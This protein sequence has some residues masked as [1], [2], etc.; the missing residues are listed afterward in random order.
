MNLSLDSK[1]SACSVLP[2]RRHSY[3]TN[4]QLSAQHVFIAAKRN[5]TSTAAV[6]W[7][8][9]AAQT[10]TV[11]YTL[12]ALNTYL[13]SSS[14]I[15]LLVFDCALT[16][17]NCATQIRGIRQKRPRLPIIVLCP[18]VCCGR[19]TAID[20]LREGATALVP[21]S[22]PESMLGAA[23]T[24][25]LQGQRFVPP[26]LLVDLETS[27]EMADVEPSHCPPK[28]DVR[29]IYSDLSL[30]P[31]ECD[32]AKY[33]AQGHS[34][35]EIA[36]RLSIQEVTVKVYASSIYRKLGVR[37]RTQAAARLLAECGT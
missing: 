8:V 7:F 9:A 12:E 24:L 37:N 3:S 20:M 2:V 4:W 30:S 33:L 36:H 32:V 28:P 25:A 35:K 19:Q 21:S 26:H 22:M 17:S 6:D 18:E 23:A 10:P 31:R 27:G 34:N 11:I 13:S 15:D 5:G 14:L 1:V 29:S 16:M